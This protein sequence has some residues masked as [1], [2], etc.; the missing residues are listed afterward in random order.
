MEMPWIDAHYFALCGACNI[1]KLK[2]YKVFTTTANY[3]GFGQRKLAHQR[4]M[5]ATLIMVSAYSM[6]LMNPVQQKPYWPDLTCH[7]C[8]V[9]HQPL[10]E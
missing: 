7:C 8:C 9:H 1:P 6:Y 3:F 4:V 2:I 10:M 5:S